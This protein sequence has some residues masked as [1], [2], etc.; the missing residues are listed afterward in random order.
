MKRRFTI[1]TAAFALLAI[2]AIPMGM[3]GQ[4]TYTK[5]TTAPSD[6]SGTYVIVADASNVIFTGQSGSNNYGGYANVTISDN[7]VT[8]NFTA[9]EV[10]IEQSGDFYSIKH[11]NSSKY[12]GWTSGNYLYFS[13]TAPSTNTYRWKLSTSSI[14]NANDDTR[15][16]QYNSGSPRFACYTSSQKVAYLYKKEADDPTTCATP[17]FSPAAGTYTE[18]QSVSINCSTEGAT[19]YYTTNGDNPTTNSSVYS[20][21]INVST[22]TTIKAMATA[23]G[24]DNSAIATAAYTIVNIEHAGTEA[25]PYTV[26]DARNAID[27]NVGVTGVYATGIVSAIPTAWSTDYNNI[28]FNFVDN[29]GDNNFLQAYR[30]VSGTGV[31]ASTVA[32]GDVVVVY[33]NLIKYGSTYELGQGCQLV[34][35]THPVITEPTITV[36][37]DVVDIDGLLHVVQLPITYSNIVVENYESF[38]V[39][40]YDAEGEATEM[41]DWLVVGVTGVMGGNDDDYVV[42]CAIPA[43][44]GEAHT[45]Y[46]KVYA[47]DA[48]QNIVYSNLITIS[49]AAPTYAELPF[50]FNGGKADIEGTDGLYQES[51]D[52]YNASTNPTTK[53]KFDGTGDWLLL[54][55]NE[56]PGT[57]TF[58]IKNNSFSGGSFKVQTSENGVTFTDL[59]TY[60]EI[61]GT[62]NEEFT[63]LDENVRYIK[64]IYTEKVS[65]NVGLGNIALAEYTEPQ[66]YTLTV[67]P[68]ENLELITFVNDEM[69]MEDNGEIQV[70]D[71]DHIM[72]S[73]V[74]NEG[75][76]IETLMVNGVNHVN[77][78]AE[79]FTY[80]FDMPAEAV[81]ISATAIEYVAPTPSEWVLT[82]LADLTE[83]DVFVIVGD[84][85]E[86]YAMPYDGGGQNGAPAA[87]AVTVVEG[88]LS[89]EPAANIQWNLGITEDGYIFYPNGDTEN[90]LYCTSTNNGVRVGTNDN[91]V[92]T[93][94]E[95]GYLVNNATSRY[96]GIYNSQDWRCYTS[97]NNN[98]ANQTFAFYKKVVEP[99][100]ETYTLNIAG[101]GGNA[102]GYFLIASPVTVDPATIEGF[103]DGDFDLYYF[104]QEAQGT[105]WIN[106]K[107]EN[108][109]I[110]HF[111]LEPGKGYLYAHKIGG[112]FTLTGTPYTG[113]GTVTLSLAESGDYAGWNLVGNPF[114]EIAY[115]VG[116]R[117]FY[118]L[119]AEGTQLIPATNNSIEA[120]E[121][122]F[123]IATEDE[124]TITFSTN[125]SSKA[126]SQIV[127]DVTR[128]H[129][130]V[131]D[132][133][134][135][136]FGEGVLPKIQLFKHSTK[137]YITKDNQE[138]A[139][140]NSANEG[141]IP[142]SFKASENGIYTFSV[143][144][145]NVDM[146]YL[147]LID[148]MTGADIDLMATPSYSFEAKVTDYTSRFRLVFSANEGIEHGNESFAF[149]NGNEW[150][151]NN[152][153]EATLQVV[154]MT[155]RVLSTET[156]NGN[157]TTKVS[158]ATGVYM[159]RLINGNDVKTQKVV[160]K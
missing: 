82:D 5:V 56:R 157:A 101:Y 50:E 9:Y 118:T 154:D 36:N 2:L 30:C 88:T 72:L 13:T 119:N 124:E 152:D 19:I 103:T 44:Q 110:N 145:E 87:V 99:A 8:G 59:K 20:G 37:P 27:A 134:I 140:V 81:T 25:D 123:V 90:W 60:T 4:S 74:A 137:V 155:G 89:E 136:N 45:T 148:N 106:Y 120:M 144:T 153:G 95:E 71:G 47:Y 58:D 48:E 73:I 80:E 31:D 65:G 129:G 132:R 85:G 15:K 111:D 42:T 63:N 33:G 114:S 51:L 115:I 142:V 107:N 126:N 127:L 160:V 17:T 159:L 108:G 3:W 64:W 86:T 66:Q 121:G 151:I 61:N 143:N 57:L 26:A 94:S 109:G 7:S 70:N 53:L 147:H 10:E 117:K 16:L 146:D 91:N 92:F 122:V 83:N 11:I 84:N 158:A 40:F 22:N 133:A 21:A 35:L 100:T 131:I 113:D 24:Y 34:S 102:G 43:N 93:I 68:F 128:N 32:V 67:E 55:F 135:V 141:E 69:I 105:E 41:P 1:L 12:L 78:I 14:L 54:Q 156:V 79:D 6:W 39:Q 96:V 150:I 104:D 97:I 28:T 130:N 138:F 38:G 52:D 18:A 112:E 125:G 116:N 62:L 76:V 75:Y 29:E 77:D 23:E 49:Q 139:I 46:L 98:I 149:F